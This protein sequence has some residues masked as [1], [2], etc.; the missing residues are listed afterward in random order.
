MCDC[1]EC[2]PNKEQKTVRAFPPNHAVA[3]EKKP[4]PIVLAFEP[5]GVSGW[6]RT[7]SQRVVSG[8]LAVLA[9]FSRRWLWL[10]N[11]FNFMWVALAFGVPLAENAGW[12]WLSKSLFAFCNLVCVQNP[13]HSLYLG[14][15]QMALCQRCLAIYAVM[16]LLGLFFGLVRNRLKP[17]KFWQFSLFC[18]PIALDGFT[19]L[20]GWRVST[21]ELRFVTGGL[22]A[23]GVVWYLYPGFETIANRLKIWVSRNRQHQH[24]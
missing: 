14:T 13:G 18:V 24:A 5:Q 23:L 22:F 4:D 3:L 2:Q 7:L 20:F 9:F 6:R 15:H 12:Q 1:A 10:L 19:Q 17:L 21:W 11:A 16:G 8:L